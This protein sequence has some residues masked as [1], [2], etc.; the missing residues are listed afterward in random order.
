MWAEID[1]LETIVKTKRGFFKYNINRIPSS[2]VKDE[3]GTID[4]Q[5]KLDKIADRENKTLKH[6]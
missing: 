6:K 4:I 1:N 2:D 5:E 3:E